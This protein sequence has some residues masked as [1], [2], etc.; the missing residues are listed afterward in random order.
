LRLGA[1]RVKSKRYI[2][3]GPVLPPNIRTLGALPFTQKHR[4]TLRAWLREEGWPRGTMNI[5]MLEGYLIAL[6]VWPVGLSSG[7]WL[8]HIWGERGW[9]VPAKIAN[10]NALQKFVVLIGGFLQELDHSLS[11]G[12]LRFAAVIGA[13]E[14]KRR[15][16]P[17]PGCDWAVGF[18]SA[19]QQHCQGLKYRSAAAKAAATVIAKW[20]SLPPTSRTGAELSRAVFVLAAERPSRGPLGELEPPVRDL[21]SPAAHA[22]TSSGVQLGG[23]G[24]S[25]KKEEDLESA[26]PQAENR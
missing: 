17:S 26:I 18:M 9:K 25:R 15:G 1:K 13:P 6:L 5:E 10:A 7:A 21:V 20:A 11:D 4:E 8:P 3:V 23:S 24:R 14:L 12:P 22:R 16:Q 19:L 2:E